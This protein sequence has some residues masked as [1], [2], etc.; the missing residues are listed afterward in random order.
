[1]RDKLYEQSVKISVDPLTGVYSRFAYNEYIANHKNTPSNNFVVFLIDI[2]GLKVA[3]DTLGHEAGDEL[4][5]GAAACITSTFKDKGNTYRI[6]GDEF[7]VFGYMNKDEVEST[8]N[9][10]NNTINNWSGT[11]VD[12]LS[13]SFGFAHYDDYP[14]LTIEEL[15][16]KADKEMYLMKKH[17]YDVKFNRI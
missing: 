1:M 15:T 10:L 11:R 2:N 14:N 8:I 4:I 5:C 3:N 12:N 16:K 7:V 9:N 13:I 6:G 17:Y